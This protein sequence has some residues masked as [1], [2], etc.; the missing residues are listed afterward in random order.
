VALKLSPEQELL[1]QATAAPGFR[2]GLGRAVPLSVRWDRLVDMAEWHRLSPLL[3]RYLRAGGRFASVPQR[4][5][6]QLHQVAAATTARNL[7]LQAAL[8][9]VV[10]TLADLGIPAM[11]LK[12]AALIEAVYPDIGLRPMGDL[13]I[14]VPR[15]SIEDAQG[16]IEALGYAVWGVRLSRHDASQLAR[17]HHHY[18]LERGSVTVEL[19]H[20][21]TS[22]APEFD[23]GGFWERAVPGPGNVPHLL[24]SPEDLLLHGAVHFT[25]DRIARL[26]S[27]LGQ[28]AD[29]AWIVAQQPIDWNAIATRARDYGVGHQ[30]FLALVAGQILLDELAPEDTIAAVQPASY[31][32]AL[33]MQ[34]VR[35][36]VLRS[37]PGVPL[38]RLAFAR[39]SAFPG[40]LGLD[41]YIGPDEG[42]RPSV[43]RL[44]A[45]RALA[46]GQLVAAS[47]VSPRGFLTDLR[48]GWW[49]RSL[50]L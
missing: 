6:D 11:L 45:R 2:V 31:R 30:L 34:F 15:S 29:L 12:G 32:S 40:R 39:G 24:P 20:H 4:V 13:D 33:G 7:S 47:A 38:D 44:R 36:C 10:A 14:L 42:T 26:A 50:R 37:Q 22:A 17:H 5:L 23:I 19:H 35:Q 8:G 48:L 9:E 41:R 28:L 43:A 16:A 27:G 49:V 3:W 21:V 25:V 18:P 46:S 1:V